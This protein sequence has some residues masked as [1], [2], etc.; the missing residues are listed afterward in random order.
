[1]LVLVHGLVT[2]GAARL[3]RLDL[4]V[5]SVASQANVGGGTSALAVARSLGRGDLVLP[6]VLIGSLGNAVG[7]FL[8]FWAAEA[9]F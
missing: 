2:Y 3:M 5:A 4:D 6:A 1:V 8:G 9:L 7:T